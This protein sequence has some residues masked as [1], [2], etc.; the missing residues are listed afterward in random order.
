MDR[1][2]IYIINKLFVYCSCAA[3]DNWYGF[4]GV[5]AP[6]YYYLTE[7]W[8]K[9]VIDN[10]CH[11]AFRQWLEIPADCTVDI[12][13]LSKSKFGLNIVDVSMKFT[14]C[15][16]IIRKKLSNAENEDTQLIY[17]LIRE[18]SN[19]NYDHFIT[20]K[21]VIKDLRE[22]KQE[23]ITRDLTTQSLVVK[24]LCQESFAENG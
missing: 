12:I 11:N 18:K 5:H 21:N 8:V 20:S 10:K 13:M 24:A 15:Q 22:R 3:N 2:F 14:Q 4:H 17:Q 7:T 9:E 1:E 6:N 19:I 23:H 16:T